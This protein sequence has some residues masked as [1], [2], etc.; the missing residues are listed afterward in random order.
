M[1]PWKY[2]K[3][4]QIALEKA[5]GGIGWNARF[6]Y[7]LDRFDLMLKPMDY[8]DP[9][10]QGMDLYAPSHFPGEQVIW[11]DSRIGPKEE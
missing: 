4:I 9:T 3:K 11:P 1:S 8:R 5:A 10:G 6:L 2:H 7:W